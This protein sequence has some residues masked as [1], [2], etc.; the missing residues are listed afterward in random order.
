MT[1]DSSG[2]GLTRQGVVAWALFAAELL[3]ALIAPFFVLL[4]QLSIPH[5]GTSCDFELLTWT[6]YAFIGVC[7]VIV[8]ASVWAMVVRQHRGRSIWWIPVAGIVLILAGVL[9]A[10][11]LSDV[12]LLFIT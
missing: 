4:R 11:L 12:A 8:V 2:R 5:C 6:G 1:P 7:L 3:V 9:G 10:N